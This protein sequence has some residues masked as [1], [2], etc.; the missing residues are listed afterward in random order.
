MLV[1]V[2]QLQQDQLRIGEAIEEQIRS[3]FYRES[4]EPGVLRQMFLVNVGRTRGGRPA[5]HTEDAVLQEAV[6]NL[7]RL[8]VVVLERAQL[9]MNWST[10][11]SRGGSS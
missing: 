9:A 8:V 11:P 6:T 7:A 10:K 1:H 4:A 2:S 5:M 3:W